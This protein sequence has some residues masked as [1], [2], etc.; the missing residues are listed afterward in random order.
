MDQVSA[1]NARWSKRPN[2]NGMEQVRELLT[3]LDHKRLDGVIV[4]TNFFWQIQPCKE[5]AKFLRI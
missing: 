1:S 3:L 4:V 5:R 2:S